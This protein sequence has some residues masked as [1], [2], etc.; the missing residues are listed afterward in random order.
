MSVCHNVIVFLKQVK[1]W[2]LLVYVSPGFMWM[3]VVFIY[4]APRSC[5]KTLYLYRLIHAF[6]ECTLHCT[7]KWLVAPKLWLELLFRSLGF[8]AARNADNVQ[9]YN[10]SI[11]HFRFQ[12]D[13]P[14]TFT[15]SF[16]GA[17]G[18][19]HSYIRSPSGGHEDCFIQEMDTGLY[20]IRLG[21][22]RAVQ[23]Q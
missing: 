21:A 18:Q 12:V 9:F 15:V 11:I 20:A 4:I 10:Y 16:N 23:F 22:A 2:R 3:Y 1:T 8:A 5:K 6:I 14:A 17:S 13:K 7:S 19:L